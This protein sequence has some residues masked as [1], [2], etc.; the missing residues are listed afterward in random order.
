MFDR[1]Q[2]LDPRRLGRVHPEDPQVVLKSST[3]P[4]PC[5][6]I[7]CVGNTNRKD[8]AFGVIRD[9][10]VVAEDKLRVKF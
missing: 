8:A 9:D 6:R 7:L 10:V 3:P 1:G 4:P 5:D 2:M